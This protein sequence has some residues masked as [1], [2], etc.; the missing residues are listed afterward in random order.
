M[1]ACSPRRARDGSGCRWHF[2]GRRTASGNAAR[3]RN[4]RMTGSAAPRLAV[5]FLAHAYPRYAG[6]PVGSF[7]HNLAVAL[8]TE[9]IDVTVVAPGARD[10]AAF[11]RLDG[12]PVHRFRYAPRRLE[13]L[14]YT[15][16]MSAQVQGG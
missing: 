15:G 8:R 3:T 12:I 13:T 11:E 2:R 16:T 7:V 4:G 6:D 14:A 1:A 10:V 9:G 5:V